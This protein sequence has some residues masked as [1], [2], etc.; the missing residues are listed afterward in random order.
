MLILR[1]LF[2]DARVRVHLEVANRVIMGPSEICWKF[3]C[4]AY[5]VQIAFSL[6]YR[7]T[8][9]A[10]SKVTLT[11]MVPVYSRLWRLPMTSGIETLRRPANVLGVNKFVY[12]MLND[13]PAAPFRVLSTIAPWNRC[14]PSLDFGVD[15]TI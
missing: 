6:S 3:Q 13:L 11:G 15:M 8:S 1:F 7:L 12:L 5:V 10:G 4:V 14:V 2:P 9:R